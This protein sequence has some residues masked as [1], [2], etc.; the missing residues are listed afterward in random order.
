MIGPYE[1]RTCP[2]CGLK[3][4]DAADLEPGDMVCTCDDDFSE[5]G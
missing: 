5:E 2:D 1:P 4:W 3:T